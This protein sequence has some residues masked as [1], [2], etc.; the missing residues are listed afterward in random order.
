MLWDIRRN[1]GLLKPEPLAELEGHHYSVTNLYMDPYKIVTCGSDDS[2]VKVWEA[3][4]GELTN[5]L[6][7]FKG[8]SCNAMAVDGCRIAT[9]TYDALRF[10]DFNNATCPAMKLENDWEVIILVA[11]KIICTPTKSWQS[12]T[13]C[14]DDLDDMLD[15][16]F[17]V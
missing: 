13:A 16:D 14:P 17:K 2:H 10:R 6:P 3:S 12:D 7:C 11:L 4:T 5:S 1:Q 8:N 15:R 9:T